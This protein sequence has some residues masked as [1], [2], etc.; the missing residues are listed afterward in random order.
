MRIAGVDFEASSE[1][2]TVQRTDKIQLCF[3]HVETKIH[4]KSTKGD[5]SSLNKTLHNYK[6][7]ESELDPDYFPLHEEIIKRGCNATELHLIF[8]AIADHNNYHVKY[9]REEQRDAHIAQLAGCLHYNIWKDVNN[10][11]VK[12]TND[13]RLI[14]DASYAKSLKITLTPEL[15]QNIIRLWS[16]DNESAAN[17]FL[18]NFPEIY[19]V[20]MF[21]YKEEIYIR[22]F[23]CSKKCGQ[24]E[25]FPK[26]PIILPINEE[27]LIPMFPSTISMESSIPSSPNVFG[28]ESIISESICSNSMLDNDS[29]LFPCFVNDD[30]DINFLNMID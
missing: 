6:T 21:E 7:R 18:D 20:F 8:N 15:S 3:D 25:F 17:T 22:P 27:E 14:A 2:R 24:K 13:S 28:S 30:Y 19:K 4:N 16:S 5:L 9:R 26:N 29:N 12:K 10:L 11:I 1:E 23:T